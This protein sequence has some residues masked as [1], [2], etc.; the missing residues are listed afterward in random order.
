MS[1]VEI[2]LAVGVHSKMMRENGTGIYK[3]Q[4]RRG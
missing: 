4:Q 1:I 2:A 3:T